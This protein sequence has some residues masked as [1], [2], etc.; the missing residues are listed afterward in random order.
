MY[1]A[2]EPVRRPLR[3][4]RS[5]LAVPGSS[6][7]MLARAP[8]LA[9]DQVFLDLED[10]VSPDA[11][12]ESRD[13]VIQALREGDWSTKTRVVRVNDCTTRWTYRDVITVVEA[14]GEHLDCV[15]LPKVQDAGQ[16]QFVDHLLTQIELEK[17]WERGRIGLELQVENAHGLVNAESILAAS[18]R[19]ETLILGP[20][21]MAA[22]LG[23]PT[24]TVGG[25]KPDYPGDHWHW[26]HFTIL[27]HARKAGIQ[28]IDGPYGKIPDLDGFR[29]TAK[30]SRAIGFDGK[31]VLHPTQIDAA[32]EIYSENQSDFDRALDILEVLSTT[33]EVERP[34]AVMFG[35]EMIDEAS[36]KLAMITAEKGKREGLTHRIVP[37]DVPIEERAAWRRANAP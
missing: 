7:R 14:A 5:C 35:N 36:R 25:L 16:V 12:E 8:S 33:A 29:E 26:V 21:D 4:R 17:G 24:L 23:M 13:H 11:K 18:P 22:N 10:S 1:N 6:L 2:S 32:N 19:T 20:G 31:W 3:L 34:G 15:M 28:A 27:V 37:A 30:R 9:A